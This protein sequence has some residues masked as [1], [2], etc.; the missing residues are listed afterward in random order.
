MNNIDAARGWVFYWSKALNS[1]RGF[2]V[3]HTFRT[4]RREAQGEMVKAW[5]KGDEPFSLVWKRI[6]RHG[7]RV[8]RTT[9][10]V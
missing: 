8:R 9:V 6:Y 5:N 4:T 2:V 3:G 10:A 1:D 7:G